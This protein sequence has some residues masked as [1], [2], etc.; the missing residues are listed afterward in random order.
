MHGGPAPTL[1]IKV[2]A[3][4]ATAIPSGRAPIQRSPVLCWQ[5][6]ALVSTCSVRA[7]SRKSFASRSTEAAA[8]SN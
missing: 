4:S 8:V 3:R 1:R 6:G 7:W 2:V 5:V